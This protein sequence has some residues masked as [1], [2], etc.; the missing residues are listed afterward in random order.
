MGRQLVS[1]PFLRSLRHSTPCCDLMMLSW[2]RSS[3]FHMENGPEAGDLATQTTIPTAA[4]GF[5][6]HVTRASGSGFRF[7][8]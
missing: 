1:L 7:Y 6:G 3:G 4:P 8:P 5:K 2:A